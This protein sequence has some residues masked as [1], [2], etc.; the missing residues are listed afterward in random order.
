V[1][2]DVGDDNVAI[3][4]GQPGS[5]GGDEPSKNITITD[6][7]FEHGHGISI[8][9]EIAGGVQNV[10]VERVTF[11]GGD[12]A[13]RIKANRDRG[14]DVSNISFK[15]ITMD[16]IVKASISISEYYPQVMPSG[17]VEALPVGRLTP[18]FHNIRIENVKGVN[19]AWAGAIVGLPESPV[20][21]IVL[22]NVNIQAV[23]GLQVAYA[24]VTTDG[25]VV[26]VPEGSQ[27]VILGPG[28]EVSEV[29][30]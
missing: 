7:T 18:H 9:S 19:G 4:S 3:K 11:K 10:R 14:N 25:M 15:D 27:A 5:A 20:T 16:G 17:P 22:K 6:C 1:Y 8:G 26:T 21:D 30:K 29:K 2:E 12:Q 23:K 24:D 13:I 28:G